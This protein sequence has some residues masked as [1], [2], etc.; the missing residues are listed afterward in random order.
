[1]EKSNW[2]FTSDNWNYQKE[3][4]LFTYSEEEKQENEI[5]RNNANL[6]LNPK[7]IP[8]YPILLDQWYSLIESLIIGFIDFF[9]QNNDRFYC[10]NEQLASLLR[11]SEPTISNAIKNLEKKGNVKLHKKMK[12]GGGT[13]RFLTLESKNLISENQKIWFS[14]VKK[15]DWIYNNIIDNKISNSNELDNIYSPKEKFSDLNSNL[16]V[17]PEKEHPQA[18]VAWVDTFDFYDVNDPYVQSMM[19]NKNFKKN[20]IDTLDKLIKKGYTPETI[21]TVLCFIKQDEFW[22]KQIRSL[23]KLLKKNPDWVMYIDVMIDK[24]KQWKPKCIDLDALYWLNK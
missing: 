14:K 22:S 21:Q 16:P 2:S 24:I 3:D 23:Q 4:F 5:N 18:P 20:N 15:L 13:I 11:C 12:A 10:T 9:L 17:S 19:K 1:M 6:V 8:L 7:F